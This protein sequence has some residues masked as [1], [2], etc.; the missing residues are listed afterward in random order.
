MFSVRRVTPPDPDPGRDAGRGRL[1]AVPGTPDAVLVPAISSVRCEV[2]ITDFAGSK[3]SS[4]C[5]PL[6]KSH[7]TETPARNLSAPSRGS[8][9]V[10][11]FAT[12]S[13]STCWR[14]SVAPADGWGSSGEG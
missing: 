2:T 3:V 10:L 9:V 7:S 13:R 8:S 4:L 14:Y 6:V 12:R 11:I 1:D 5:S